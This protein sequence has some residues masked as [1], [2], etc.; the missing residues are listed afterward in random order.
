M[1]C[2]EYTSK[3]V[4]VSK[5]KR[6]PL[7]QTPQVNE[8]FE[9]LRQQTSKV[10]NQRLPKVEILRNAICYIESLESMLNDAQS[11]T[12]SSDRLADLK[13]AKQA[14]WASPIKS[15]FPIDIDLV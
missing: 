15:N 12:E 7:A 5:Q 3:N 10:P 1:A 8:A 2:Q 6:N 11:A 14:S 4:I 9:I 13:A